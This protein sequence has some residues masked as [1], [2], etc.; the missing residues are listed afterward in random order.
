LLKK[1]KETAQKEKYLQTIKDEIDTIEQKMIVERGEN[2]LYRF[3]DEV[4][5]LLRQEIFSRYYFQK[6]RIEASFDHDPEIKK[7]IELLNDNEQ[8][9]LILNP[10]PK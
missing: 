8:Y 2:D 7:A 10:N 3:K 4:K 1:L 9:Q 6:G 5:M